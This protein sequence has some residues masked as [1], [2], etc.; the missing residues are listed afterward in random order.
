MSQTIPL[1]TRLHCITQRYARTL[2][3]LAAILA[4]ILIPQAQA[5][6]AWIQ[7]FVFG[8]LFLSF[9]GL[10]F[11]RRALRPSLLVVLLANVCV[12]LVAFAL[13]ARVDKTLALAGF[14][15]GI[16]P[17]AIA[18]PV[19]IAL[20]ERRV[21]YVVMAVLLNNVAIALLVPFLLPWLAGGQVAISMWEVLGSVLKVVILPLV[22]ARLVHHLP[23]FAQKP[24]YRAKRF[25]F[26]LWMSSLFLVTSKASHFLYNNVSVPWTLLAQIAATSFVLCLI[27]FSLGAL[28][29]GREF[30]REASQ[31][32]GQKN[33]SFT[34]WLA[35]TFVNPVVALGPTFYVIFHNLYNSFQLY[36]FAKEKVRDVNE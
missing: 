16:T 33:L 13:L 31:A 29:G 7:Y 22:L 26:V 1:S 34:I 36:V 17:T 15:T 35:L 20:L 24:V 8:M 19:V 11:D 4:G 12:A 18:A 14:M 2:A 23:E 9:V 10:Q 25:T 30:R 32:L 3:L 5:F 28:I 6:S 21:A 27:N